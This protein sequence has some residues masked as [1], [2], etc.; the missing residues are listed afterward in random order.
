VDFSNDIGSGTFQIDIEAASFVILLLPLVSFL[1]LFLFAYRLPN[2]GDIIATT[3]MGITFLTSLVLFISVHGFEITPFI[4]PWFSISTINSEIEFTA[5]IKLNGLSSIMMVL[6]S[7]ISFLVHLY[8]LEYMKGKRN[9]A[10][11]FPYLGIFTFSMMGIVLSDNLLITFMFWELVGFSSYLL[12]GFWYDKEEAIK[13]AKKA[14]LFNRIGD[15]GFLIALLILYS[16][17][18]TLELSVISTEFT[19]LSVESKWIT[20]IGL[21]IFAGC[22][23][24]SAQFPL[25]AWL[26][27]AMEGP[28]PVSAL[29]HAA[30]MVA[31]G[32]FLLIKV[33]FLL[34]ADV[35]MIVAFIGAFTAFMG[36]LPAL[37]QNDIKKVLAYST[38]SQLGYM[39][40]AVGVGAY[41]ASLFHLITHGFFKACLF[42]SAGAVIHSMHQV[43]H[44]L[45]LKG[46][47]KDFDSQ[48]MRLMGGFRKKM[49]VTFY[50]YAISA[51]ALIG[52]PFFTG[53]LSKDAIMEGAVNWA[54]AQGN[55]FFYIIPLIGYVTIFLTA[56]YMVRQLLMIFFGEFRFA[57]IA[58]QAKEVFSHVQDP[59]LL[60]KIPLVVLAFFCFWFT[61]SINPFSAASGWIFKS[62]HFI[63]LIAIPSVIIS[64]GGMIAAYYFFKPGSVKMEDPES[65]S[66]VSGLLVNNWYLD[67][68]YYYLLVIPGTKSA[69]FFNKA[70]K[71][72][73]DGFIH[74]IAIFH[75]VLAHVIAWF[76]RIFVDGLV[77]LIVMVVKRGG[78]I[79]RSIQTGKVQAYYV[80]A[81][82]VTIILILWISIQ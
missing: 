23:G 78:V 65:N 59:S 71:K 48:D 74:F 33:N 2:K 16:Y 1:I 19:S 77:H 72:I 15:T 14:F 29:I 39:V 32:V 26:P 35:L 56:M 9:Y 57:K 55:I 11:Y 61:F 17:F 68:V 4:Y 46:Y 8:S 27:D 53:F 3:L 67:S 40:M 80:F 25:Q 22:I 73:I 58:Y 52:L 45:F 7:F 21:G 38:I 30:T 54:A 36:A 64:L 79:S 49:P 24:K 82:L 31:A 69:E 34:N 43:K 18:D 63:P 5:S 41:D 66:P 42:L 13:A 50:T 6:V 28:T 10:R 60:I 51:M 70:D 37:F 44:E 47:Y 76:D 75:V 62:G 20:L 12:I 81:L